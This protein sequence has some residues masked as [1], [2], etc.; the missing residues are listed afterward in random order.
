MNDVSSITV[1]SGLPRSGT[2]LLMQMLRAGGVP[3][4]SDQV[5]AEDANNPRGYLE[6][7]PVKRL[8]RDASWIPQARG[9]AVKVIAQL[10]GKLP[11]DERY[12]II[13]MRRDVDEVITSQMQML[14]RLGTPSTSS[15]PPAQLARIFARQ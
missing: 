13:M 14:E 5:R 11:P 4:L 12:H 9:K 6:F 10:I 1:V 7:E 2:S 15:V 8:A 3:I